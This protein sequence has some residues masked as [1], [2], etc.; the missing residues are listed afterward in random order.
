MLVWGG[1]FLFYLNVESFLL[2]SFFLLA[3]TLKF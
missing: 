3:L 2:S 1:R